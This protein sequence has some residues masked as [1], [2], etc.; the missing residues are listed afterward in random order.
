MR[1]ETLITP[2]SRCGEL[3]TQVAPIF[4]IQVPI[5][6]GYLPCDCAMAV[7]AGKLS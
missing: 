4:A 5:K 3:K 6:N 7:G 1:K 2:G